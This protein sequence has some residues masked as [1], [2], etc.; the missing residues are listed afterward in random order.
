MVFI[1]GCDPSF[2]HSIIHECQPAPQHPNMSRPYNIHTVGQSDTSPPQPMPM[3]NTAPIH[4]V[5]FKPFQYSATTSLAVSS[6]A[7]TGS[8]VISLAS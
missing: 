7:A 2:R 1:T 5:F 8:Q 6:T 3:P 4:L